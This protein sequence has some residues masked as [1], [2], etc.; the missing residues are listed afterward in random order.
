MELLRVQL[1]SGHEV[2]IHRRGCASGTPVLY[3][4]SPATS[5][6]ELNG[7]GDAAAHECG[8][9]L[10]TIVRRSLVHDGLS[11]SFMETVASDTLLACQALELDSIHVLG[12][13]GGAPY[14][15]A[16]TAQLG[17][18][19]NSVHLISPVPGQLVGDSAIEHQSERLQAIARTTPT[20]DW[21]QSPAA[22]R[23]YAALAGPW[24]FDFADIR[25]HVTIWAPE[26]DEIVPPHLVEQLSCQLLDSETI[27][28]AGDHNWVMDNWLSVFHRIA[29][30]FRGDESQTR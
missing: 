16:A 12:W 7:D 21:A 14:A 1:A 17:A 9:Q 19:A 30:P 10:I 2:E 29:E 11:E 5:G 4:H 8:V 13:S 26:S 27:V 25:Q 22:F 20:S 15:L 24:S 23:D 28:V 18:L 3:F 6:E